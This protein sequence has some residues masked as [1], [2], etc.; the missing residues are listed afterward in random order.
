M[1]AIG[2]KTYLRWSRSH[3]KDWNSGLFADFVNLLAPRSGS[4]F[5][6]RIRIQES[7]INAVPYSK[8]CKIYENLIYTVVKIQSAYG[9]LDWQTHSTL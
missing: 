3:L 4:A 5:L 6:I 2:H 7:Q 9:K 1:L 8:Y